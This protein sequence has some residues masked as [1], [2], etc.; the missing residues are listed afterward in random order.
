MLVEERTAT[1]DLELWREGSLTN[2]SPI[3]G[4]TVALAAPPESLSA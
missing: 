3:F 4:F 2:I 1:A